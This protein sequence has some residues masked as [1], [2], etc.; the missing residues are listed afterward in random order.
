MTAKKR[1][2]RAWVPKFLEALSKLGNV[3]LACS[4]AEVSRNVAYVHRNTN[5]EFAERWDDA[6]DEA[7]DLLEHECRRR[8]AHG[9]ERERW[10]RI[11]TDENGRPLFKMIVER[12]YSDV[13]LMFL[14]KGA[15]PE[16]YRDN[17]DLKTLVATIASAQEHT[18]GG[19]PRVAKAP[20]RKRSA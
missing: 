16:K 2:S 7:V 15:R 18:D 14:I 4:H 13:L 8:A 20:G 12:E 10:T 11:G 9:V 5:A 3:R 17:F 19:K 1:E 6:M